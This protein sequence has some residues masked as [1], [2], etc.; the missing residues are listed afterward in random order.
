MKL[1]LASFLQRENFGPGNVISICRG[2]KPK[3]CDVKQQFVH[4]IPAQSLLDQYYLLRNND[5]KAAGELFVTGYQSQLQQTIDEIIKEA[6][7]TTLSPIQVLPFKDGDTLCS[8]ERKQNNNYRKI[9]APYLERL[10]Y[11]VVLN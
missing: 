1:F 3:D 2:S 11:E 9:L 4:F 6:A 8:W 5:Q 7:K 10:G